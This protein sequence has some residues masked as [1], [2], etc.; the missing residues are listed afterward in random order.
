MLRFVI[1]R[2]YYIFPTYG[3]I[4]LLFL[5]ISAHAGILF[6]L[7]NVNLNNIDSYSEFIIECKPRANFMDNTKYWKRKL[8][9]TKSVSLSLRVGYRKIC[10]VKKSVLMSLITFF[11]SKI[12]PCYILTLHSYSK[13]LPILD[14]KLWDVNA[15][16]IGTNDYD[17]SGFS[18]ICLMLRNISVYL[19]W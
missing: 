11:F 6:V 19:L 8:V 16:K 17:W 1:I 7:G 15:L 10:S 12:Q 13:H 9:S 4:C 18:W 14:F 3:T 2:L 5:Y